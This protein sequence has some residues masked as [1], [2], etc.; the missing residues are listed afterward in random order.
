MK[1]KNNGNI[2]NV[3]VKN[4]SISG[5]CRSS[6]H[7]A[8]SYVG[9]IAGYNEGNINNATATNNSINCYVG[10]YTY[11]ND[12]GLKHGY[13]YAGGIAGLNRGNIIVNS[14]SGN[15]LTTGRWNEV[16]NGV[17]DNVWNSDRSFYKNDIYNQ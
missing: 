6:A 9:S 14:Y 12:G 5:Y 13:G 8:Y 15:K 4:S 7:K 11:A 10:I 17:N 3:T 1:T 16:S 2:I